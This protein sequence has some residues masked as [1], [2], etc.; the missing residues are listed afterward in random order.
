MIG[1]D[2]RVGQ[3]LGVAR[4]RFLR[5]LEQRLAEPAC[6]LVL[7]GPD[8]DVLTDALLLGWPHAIE[9]VA[10]RTPFALMDALASRLGVALNGSRREKHRT[11]RDAWLA[12]SEL[13]V[14]RDARRIDAESLL[15]LDSLA[16][17]DGGS[18]LVVDDDAPAVGGYGL[19]R[20]PRLD[21]DAIAEWCTR[22]D[23]IR[24]LVEASEGS[25]L[26]LSQW[27]VG[28]SAPAD[29]ELARAAQLVAAADGVDPDRLH[30]VVGFR[31][32]DTEWAR[33]GVRCVRHELRCSAQPGDEARLEWAEHAWARHEVLDAM[34]LWL[35]A[36]PQRFDAHLDEALAR[37][38]DAPACAAALLKESKSRLAQ[39]VGLLREIGRWG[40][41]RV[42][43][44]EWHEDEGSDDSAYALA[45]LL[46]HTGR[47]ADAE[48]PEDSSPRWSA[49]RAEVAFQRGEL[50]SAARDARAVLD[51]PTTDRESRLAAMQTWAKLAVGDD[52]ESL[53]R[54][55]AYAAEAGDDLRHGSYAASG[56]AVALIR[57]RR[58]DE[59]LESLR[60]GAELAERA[61]DVKARALA[62]HNLAVALH[63][64][65]R[66]A[67]ARTSYETALRWLR[68]LAHAS[69]TAR[70]A[71]N[72]GELYDQLGAHERALK[73]SELGAQIAGATA[74]PASRAEGAL[75]RARALL[76][77][78]RLESAEAALQSIHEL[79]PLL[80]T[81]RR[82]AMVILR[83]RIDV[84]AGRPE[85]A[86]ERLAMR[87]DALPAV[88]RAELEVARARALRAYH[89][90]L[91]RELDAAES[92]LRHARESG[93]RYWILE[94]IRVVLDAL[95]SRGRAA[96]ELS[97]E[98]RAIEGELS[99]AVPNDLTAAWQARRREEPVDAEI[100]GR[101]PRLHQ[102]LEL[103]RRVAPTRCTVLLR[104]ES[105]TGKELLA[106]A[107]HR[108]SGRRT[109][110][111]VRVSCAAL[112]E[113]LLL[114]ELF[115]H[116]RGAFTG[117]TERRQGRFELA[118]GGTLF[119]DE[120]GEL[121]PTVQAALLRVLQDRTF[122]RV[123][124][125][126]PITV[127][128]R[129]IAATHRDLEAMVHEGTFRA[130]LYYRLNELGVE[131][132]PLRERR[133]DV[134]LLV[135]HVLRR[136]S[137]EQGI[138]AKAVSPAAMRRLQ[139]YDW[140]GNVR[141]LENIVQSA[142][143]FG[144][145]G[146]LEP[147]DFTLPRDSE[148]PASV[149]SD[150]YARLA[151]GE[152][153]LRDLK[154]ELEREFVARALADCGGNI[155]KAAELLGMKR[156]RVSQLVKEYGLRDGPDAWKEKV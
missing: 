107:I 101:S 65:D 79:A 139:R 69:S 136:I 72:L 86:L 106:E 18:V 98:A 152:I 74:A 85:L 7:R 117:A 55:D 33:A 27:L 37:L 23:V 147:A 97:E 43:A 83:A 62:H 93:S 141:Q 137:R 49:L 76:A 77:L 6:R 92:A 151:R 54:Y 120:V 91:G 125:T 25:A 59:A 94:S 3:V 126:E 40:E 124:G 133:D 130:D 153:S 145:G 53:R 84:A 155:T 39:R 108:A 89:G 1:D 81:S 127:D 135:E 68:T 17:L 41:A 90:P 116:E 66:Y 122:E 131:L 71:Y 99:L 34:R 138:A 88:R 51:D 52:G 150:A 70:C 21:A 56:R 156:P 22:P 114:S 111:L 11:L 154:K 148:P 105:G 58:L 32:S 36:D 60:R 73:M 24:R 4:R 134:P 15:W 75:L 31:A 112:V 30:D 143:L 20:V 28:G 103:A 102:A 64:S 63:L 115:G 121:S 149:E 45:W 46:T 129:V 19:S 119:L 118:E 80:D 47:A 57:M 87:D 61:D 2:P 10:R 44:R 109:K 104:G 78:D 26:T 82:A 29:P 50:E 8:A 142:A 95:G 9:V 16:G 146:V 38:S 100:I 14:V 110:P 48:I 96:T 140:P 128:V 13:V 12:Q 132:P 123:G 5:E 144:V 35:R 42:A 67:D 113:S